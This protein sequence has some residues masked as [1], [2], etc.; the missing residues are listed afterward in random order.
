M[1]TAPVEQQPAQSLPALTVPDLAFLLTQTGHALTTEL[2]AALAA[3]DTTPRAHCVLAHALTG[4]LTQGQLAQLCGLDKTTMVVTLDELERTG[5]AR[6]EPSATDRRAR[7]VAVTPAGRDLVV[8]GQRIVDGVHRDVLDSLPGPHRESFI[9]AL[10]SLIGGRLAEPIPCEDT[11]RR[12][13]PRR[14]T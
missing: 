3:L 2:T 14:T 13:V 12:R 7:I 4:A 8:K 1:T 5:L 11:P 9:V 6:R 10:T